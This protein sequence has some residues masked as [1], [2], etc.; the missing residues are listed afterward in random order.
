MPALAEDVVDVFEVFEV[1]LGEPLLVGD[2]EVVVGGA[3][4]AGKN[5]L[6]EDV[7]IEAGFAAEEAPQ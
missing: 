7:G 1:A 6:E 3:K 2:E 5:P 4:P